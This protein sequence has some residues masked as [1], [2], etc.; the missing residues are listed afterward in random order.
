M[1]KNILVLSFLFF[2]S[3]VQAQSEYEYQYENLY[4]PRDESGNVVYSDI[5]DVPGISGDELYTNAR[6][7][8]LD[9]FK[10]SKDVIQYQ[11]RESGIIAGNGIINIQDMALGFLVETPIS[12]SIRVETKDE[13]FRYHISNLV[14]IHKDPKIS[15]QTVEEAFD[16]GFM[17]KRNGKPRKRIFN[18]YWLYDEMIVGLEQKI[19]D[20]IPK[21]S[22]KLNQDW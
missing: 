3:S 1:K 17:H 21:S 4:L 19:K 6:I 13:K 9:N 22:F 7:W 15:N 8:F 20:E 10:S 12:F 18:F 11:E 5:V 2:V 16:K 14:I